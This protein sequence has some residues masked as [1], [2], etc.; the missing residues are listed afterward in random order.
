MFILLE[1]KVKITFLLI[2]HTSSLFNFHISSTTM[3]KKFALTVNKS[4]LMLKV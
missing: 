2:Q 3:H 1:K 4:S